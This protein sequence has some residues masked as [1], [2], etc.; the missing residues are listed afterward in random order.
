ML[1]LWPNRESFT[2]KRK[3][4]CEYLEELFR[5]VGMT[6]ATKKPLSSS[7]AAFLLKCEEPY[8]AE[9]IKERLKPFG[10]FVEADIKEQIVALPCHTDLDKGQLDYI[11]GAFRGMINPCYTYRRKENF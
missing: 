4:N 5:Q 9:R 2:K 6:S 1:S 10:V 7:P 11:F 3:E 8:S